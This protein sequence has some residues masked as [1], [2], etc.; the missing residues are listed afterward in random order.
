MKK[1]IMSLLLT[2]VSLSLFAQT[3]MADG[4]YYTITGA[5]AAVTSSGGAAYTGSIIIPPIVTDNAVNYPVTSIGNSAFQSCSGLTSITLPNS[6]TSIGHGAFTS[7]TGLTSI[8]LPNSVTSIGMVAF[9]YCSSLTSIT[10]PNSLTSISEGT[11]QG[12]TGL[13]SL[14]MPNSLTSIGDQVLSGC[15]GLSSVTLPNALTI[16]V[17]GM[18]S[19]CTGLTSITLPNTVTTIDDNAFNS[20][21]GLTFITLPSS[22]T[23]IGSSAFSN[24]NGLTE[25]RA[26][27]IIPPYTYGLP[28]NNVDKSIPLYVPC[29]S[30][31]LY[32]S[33]NDWKEFTNIVAVNNLTIITQPKDTILVYG[34]NAPILSVA[35]D[36]NGTLKYQWY[37]NSSDNN[38]GGTK[39]LG[40]TASTYQTPFNYSVG[41]YYYYVV[42]TGGCGTLNSN[43][44]T[45][46]ITP[47]TA[48]AVG[49]IYYTGPSM[50]WTTSATSN[51][52][53]VTLS[54]TIK[55]GEP[56]GDIRTAFITF[57]VDGKLL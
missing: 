42:L 28:F 36:G 1:L 30:V 40:A 53:T 29:Q 7:C 27:S 11:F 31:D 2:A 14:T 12:C 49:D 32:K 16:I 56:C 10:L 21:T 22:V 46:S 41:N 35:A 57:T 18:F 39:I 25:M 45:V 50:A 19:G 26:N 5:M 23:T 6:V 15:T 13:T 33:A 20:C 55:N 3:F 48:M 38:T 54:A 52:A 44:A 51:T 17:R 37:K 8:T 24:C 47:Q 34:C 4:I 9:G 43:V